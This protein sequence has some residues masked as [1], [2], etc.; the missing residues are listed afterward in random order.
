M[1]LKK[2]TQKKEQE[3]MDKLIVNDHA[4]VAPA[5]GT[6]EECWYLPIFGVYPI[7]KD[8]IRIVFDSSAKHNDISLNKRT[9]FGSRFSQ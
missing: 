1:S 2:D 3:F 7:K 6:G 5:L 9:T 4:E 8:Q